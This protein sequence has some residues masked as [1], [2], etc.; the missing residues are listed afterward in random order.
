MLQNIKK[1]KFVFAIVFSSII[2]YFL[3]NKYDAK[4][5]YS[6]V[7]ELD[8]SYFVGY[9]LLFVPQ[10]IIAGRR[11]KYIMDNINNNPLSIYRSFQ[12]CIASY[13]AN[14]VIPGKMGEVVRVLWIDKEKSKYPNLFLIL[15]E[16][17]F[18]LLSVFIIFY[19]SLML[20]IKEGDL[21]FNIFLYTNFFMGFIVIIGVLVKLLKINFLGKKINFIISFFRDN[22]RKIAVVFLYSIVLWLVQIMQ[23]YLLFRSFNLEIAPILVFAGAS[24]SVLSGAVI[25]SIGGIG[26]RDATLLYFFRNLVPEVTLLSI[27]ILTAL[28]ILIPAFIGLPFLINLSRRNE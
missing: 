14:L 24:L 12:M 4:D 16:K 27:G 23:F 26:P 8:K 22:N 28:R 15:F 2:L 13:S 9:I 18:D 5:I 11:W 6:R 25:F 1:Y 20:S 7:N 10:L 17:V 21:Y 19:V 3:F